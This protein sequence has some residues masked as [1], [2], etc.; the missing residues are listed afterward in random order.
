MG[1]PIGL[2]RLL[3]D[4]CRKKPFKG[5]LMELGR[6]TLFFSMKDLQ[7][8]APHHGISLDSSVPVKPSNIAHLAERGCI[9]DVTFFSALGCSTVHSLDVSDYEGCTFNID[10]NQPVPKELHNKYDIIIDSG[11]IE[12]I[13][14]LPNVLQNIHSMLKTGGRV[15]HCSPTTNHVDHGF[16]MFSPTLFHDYYSMNRYE[17]DSSYL[18]FIHPTR[19]DVD[20]IRIFHYEPGGIDHLSQGGFEGGML[21]SLYVCARKTELSFSGVIPQQGYYRSMKSSQGEYHPKEP[22]LYANY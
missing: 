8:W 2:A 22:C 3:F 6:Q 7:Q 14:H 5:S 10:L 20:P 19:H 1:I 16:Y 15:I 9:D 21:I 13:F 11:T 12:H 18:L 17:I 4:E